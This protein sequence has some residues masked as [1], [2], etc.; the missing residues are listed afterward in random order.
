MFKKMR[1][2]QKL[3]QNISEKTNFL[4]TL[5]SVLSVFGTLIVLSGGVW[6]ATSHAINEPELFWTI[7]HIVVYSGVGM[8]TVAGLIAY[9]VSKTIIY[10]KFTMGV[11]ILVI[12]TIL[13]LISGFGDS[14]S[15]DIFG[16]D[17]LLSLSHQPL[18]LG[19]VLVS[20][21]GFL[22]LKNISNN[23]AKKL[24]PFSIISFIIMTSWLGFNLM[25]LLGG[26]VMCILVYKI[27]SSGC[28]I[29]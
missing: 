5:V 2:R 20:L 19:L 29:L 24:L 23:Y 9:I 25:L 27:F 17:G 7:Q 26:S 10:K 22:I 1:M 15:H 6:D 11:K 18:E 3:S 16:I 28:A 14:L 8:S 21:G 12:G 13:Q 4:M